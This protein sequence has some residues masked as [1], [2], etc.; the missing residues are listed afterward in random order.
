MTRH[1]ESGVMFHFTIAADVS[2]SVEEIWPD[3]DAPENPSVDD[4]LAVIQQCGGR[5]RVLRDWELASDLALTVSDGKT[6][7]EVP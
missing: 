4:V 1:R 3:G 6:F 2:L 5:Y 7:K